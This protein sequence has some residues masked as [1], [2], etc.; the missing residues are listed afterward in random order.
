MGT[1][2]PDPHPGDGREGVAD[3]GWRRD[4]VADA[5]PSLVLLTLGFDPIA[6]PDQLQE[7][8]GG[9]A[10]ALGAQR[11]ELTYLSKARGGPG[12]RLKSRYGPD[13]CNLDLLPIAGHQW[14]LKETNGF[15]DPAG[16]YALRGWEYDGPAALYRAITAALVWAM[17]TG[18]VDGEPVGWKR[19]WSIGNESPVYQVRR[20]TR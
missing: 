5:Y 11:L 10:D 13:R 3:E 15:E 2:A 17:M 20:S 1:P 19:A 14:Q 9:I 6:D 12:L 7:V 4:A 16:Y 8:Y 18:C